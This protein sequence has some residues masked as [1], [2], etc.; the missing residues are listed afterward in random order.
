LDKQA[1]KW[2]IFWCDLLKPLIFEEIEAEATNRFLKE[3]AHTEVLF[4]DGRIAKPS[5]A[6]LRRKFNRYRHGGFDALFRHAR[7]DRGKPRN[8]G[9]EVMQKAI[10]LKRE[11]PCRSPMVINQFLQEMY[12][13]TVPR[14]T[15][16]RHLKAAGAT[17]LK[18]GVLK[19]KVRKRWTREHTHDL[20]LGDFEEGPYVLSENQLLPT[21]LSAF[22]DCH[23]RY[24]VE[25][26]YYLRQNLDILID[27]LIRAF[28]IHGAPLELYLDNAKVYH[29]NGLKAACYR[30][31]IR[32]LHRPAHDPAPGGLI[33][34]FIQTA[35]G[36]F[37]AEV[38]AGQPLTLAELNR[39][40]SA[41]L[42]VCYHQEI[43]SETAES[44][45]E[46]HRKGL[47]LIREVD[48]QRV[49]ESFLQS[50][51]RT[52]NPTFSDIQVNNRYY[53]VDPKLRGDRVEV[54]FDPFSTWEQLKLY[55][56]DGAFLGLGVLHHREAA[57]PAAPSAPRGKPQ[58]SYTELLIRRHQ[59]E[60][61]EKTGSIDYRK[62][63]APRPWPFQEFARTVADLLGLKAGLTA[64]GAGE[65]E[66]LKKLYNQSR[67][68]DRDMLR[69]AFEN[70]RHPK[71]PYIVFELKKLLKGEI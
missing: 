3:L 28:S 69:K 20:W 33:E 21:H 31:N 63:I 12:S 37:E 52:V 54:R 32:L 35:Q 13:T 22:I 14:A 43:H 36:Q 30:L 48:M 9:P 26:R 42:S 34:R 62:I 50:I 10:E 58:H 6:T 23:S 44:P 56:L 27:T 7:S 57:P 60:L 70:A 55:S 1:E 51:R 46:R 24:I 49:M 47:G 15:L 67:S 61:A 18:L 16:Y 45:Q 41:W 5:V 8:T 65:L 64:F 40:F 38:R 39:A 4:P 53:R 59:Q 25:A 68:I 2:A 29:A 17:R 11:Q 71:L 66:A 19:Q